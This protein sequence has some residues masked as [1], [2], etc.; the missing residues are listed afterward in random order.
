[1]AVGVWAV[2]TVVGAE[3]SPLET[4]R[5]ALAKLI[6]TRQITSRERQQWQFERQILQERLALM[7]REIEALAGKIKDAQATMSDAD[8]KRGE[9]V[10]ENEELKKLSG[11]L[12]E[13]VA[14]LEAKLGGLVTALPEPLREKLKPLTQRLPANPR[15]TKLSVSER[16]QN[17]VGILNEVTKFNRE[18]TV[19]SEVRTLDGGRTAEVKA[20]YLG[21]GQGYFVTAKGDAAGVGR[22]SPSGWQWESANHLADEIGQAIAILQNEKVASFVPMPVE[23]K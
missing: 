23:V 1:M 5:T 13:I 11:Q 20:L 3:E 10:A 15:E 22:P 4:T 12:Q 18:V 17:V 21:L 8:R 2:A 9:L 19:A 14:R 7:D 16:F 6:E